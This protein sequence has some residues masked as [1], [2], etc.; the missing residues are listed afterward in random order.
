MGTP[1]C[2]VRPEQTVGPFPN[3][4]M[5]NRSDV[6]GEPGGMGVKPGL[7]LKFV[8][9]VGQMT[10]GACKAYQGV[11]VDFWQCDVGGLYSSYASEGTGGMN[12][13]RGYQMTDGSG[14][15]EFQT[16]F[17]GSYPGRAVHIH[18]SVRTAGRKFTSQLYFPE[19]VLS[20][21]FAQAPYSAKK[22]QKNT[23][24]GIFNGGG[25]NL[26]PKMSKAGGG[27]LAEFSIGLA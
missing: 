22:P 25:P 18:F 13:L 27:W 26:I 3:K 24:D 15:A 9:Q 21:V 19:S 12:F 4:T 8:F 5:L 10:G 14:V 6:R 7:P 2:I 11:A 1:S 16:I 20:E 17:P 23:S